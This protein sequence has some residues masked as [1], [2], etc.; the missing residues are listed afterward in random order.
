MNPFE[1]SWNIIKGDDE[2]CDDCGN[3]GSCKK[4]CDD[5]GKNKCSECMD[6]GSC[7]S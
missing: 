5:C 6:K 1:I 4:C 7:G 2:E 3:S